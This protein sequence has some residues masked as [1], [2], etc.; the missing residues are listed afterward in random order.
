[1]LRPTNALIVDDE[2]HVRVFVR[3]LLK[4]LGIETTWEARDGVEAIAKIEEHSPELLLLDVNLPLMSGL[5]VLA[6]VEEARPE[7]PV[8]MISSE[9][10]MK[11]VVEAMQRGAIA[12]VLKHSPRRE[13]LKALGDALD[14]LV[15]EDDDGGPEEEGR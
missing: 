2:P 9:N 8:I 3:L 11:T 4:E 7:L 13:A 12:Y 1:M 15:A 6:Q 5:E 10:A 14:S